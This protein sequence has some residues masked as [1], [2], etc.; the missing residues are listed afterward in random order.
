MSKRAETPATARSWC[1]TC[2]RVALLC[3]CTQVKPFDLEPLLV[4]VVHPKEFRNT[5]GTARIVTLSVRNSVTLTGQGPELDQSAALASLLEDPRLFPVV[6]F[7]GPRS[8]NLSRASDG[9]L[10]A[11]LPP[12]RRLAII[13]VDGTWSLAK[14]LIRTSKKLSALP[15]MSFDV[16]AP[17]DYRF[18]RQPRPYCLSTVEAVHLLIE[19]LTE[20][21][22]CARPPAEAHHSMLRTFRWIVEKQLQFG[23]PG[24]RRTE[25]RRV[26]RL[27]S[28]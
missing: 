7:P 5:V 14:K 6:L 27:A 19:T 9:E 25:G 2:R 24:V 23:G 8:L 21:K 4:M 28:L 18:R 11:F 13:V 15:R 22:L 3:L 1:W 12:A 10:L 26:S 17:S 16:I 20:R